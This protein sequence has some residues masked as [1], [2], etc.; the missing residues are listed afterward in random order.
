MIYT[1]SKRIWTKTLK[2]K[3][4]TVFKVELNEKVKMN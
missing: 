1:W 2:S 3:L 4:R